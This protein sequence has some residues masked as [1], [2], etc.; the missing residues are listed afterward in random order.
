MEVPD[1]LWDA[2]AKDFIGCMREML[3]SC[4]GLSSEDASHVTGHT[5]CRTG[6][7]LLYLVDPTDSELIKTHLRWKSD[8]MAQAYAEEVLQAR[9]AQVP[10]AIIGPTQAVPAAIDPPIAPAHTAEALPRAGD[11]PTRNSSVPA[12]TNSI[13]GD[14]AA[15]RTSRGGAPQGST[16]GRAVDQVLPMTGS[17]YYPFSAGGRIW[18]GRRP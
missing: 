6:T 14:Q 3:I 1:K 5:V 10:S 9:A 17:T 16:T 11:H 2:S 7:Q 12:A 8:H 18:P 13:H 15:K 4:A